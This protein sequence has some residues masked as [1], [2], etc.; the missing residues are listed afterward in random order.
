MNHHLL[1]HS[2]WTSEGKFLHHHAT[3]L[4]SSVHVMCNIPAG[5]QFGPCILQNTF[6]DTIAFIALKSSDKRSKSYVFRVGPEAMRS[7]ALVLSWL[8]LVQAARH[9]EEQNTEAFLKGGQLYFRTTKEIHQDEELL[10]WYDQELSHL[11][12]FTD[13]STRGHNAELK[14]AKCNRVFK[15]EHPYLAHCRFLCSQVKNDMP[16]REAYEHKHIEI[17]WQHRIT[18]FHNIARDL[19]HKES[20]ASEEEEISLRKRKHEETDYPNGGNQCY[21]RKPT[22]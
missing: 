12:G 2:L 4:Y 10:V 20:S 11:L 7:S 22:S 16:S 13:I 18:D 21:W 3:V 15:N 17:K 8:R 5:A 19:E 1:P 6:H 9:R 14:C